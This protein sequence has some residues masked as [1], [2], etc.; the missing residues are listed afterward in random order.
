VVEVVVWFEVEV[1]DEV[2][3]WFEVEVGDEVEVVGVAGDVVEDVVE[4]EVEVTK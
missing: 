1:G 2:V 3:V 4:V